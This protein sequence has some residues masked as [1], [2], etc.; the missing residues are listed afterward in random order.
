MPLSCGKLS[1]ALPSQ[2]NILTI[3]GVLIPDAEE[4]AGDNEG[5][6]QAGQWGRIP[7]AHLVTEEDAAAMRFSI[8]QVVLPLPGCR[9]HYPRH[10]TA[11]VFDYK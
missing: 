4:A 2:L 8:D 5:P 1:R 9:I 10:D 3:S 7:E 6:A 11:Q